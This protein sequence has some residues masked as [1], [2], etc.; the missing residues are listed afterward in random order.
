MEM[1]NTLILILTLCQHKDTTKVKLWFVIKF[2]MR[3]N[4]VQPGKQL[5]ASAVNWSVGLVCL[6]MPGIPCALSRR[7]YLSVGQEVGASCVERLVV[8][9]P[10]LPHP[11]LST[12]YHCVTGAC[13]I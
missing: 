12:V 5:G 1:C 8:F 7:A 3:L 10:S 9:V 4:E 6:H 11:L 2:F 13:L